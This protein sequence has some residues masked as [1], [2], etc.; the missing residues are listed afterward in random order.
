MKKRVLVLSVMVIALLTA[1]HPAPVG[2]Q[3][4]NTYTSIIVTDVVSGAPVVGSTFVTDVK[5]SITNNAAPTLGV[6]GVELWLPFDPAVVS[7]VDHDGNPGNGTQVQ[8]TNGFFDGNL[9]VGANEVI[10]GAMPA[11]APADCGV[12]GACVHIAV[13]HTG[14]SGAITD[15]TG[16]VAS[17]TWAALAVGSPAISIAVVPP[18][19]LPGSVLS[20]A[21]GGT[22]DINST[23]VP[24]ITIIDAGQINGRVTR[25]GAQA[26]HANTNV[27]ALAIGNGVAATNVTNANGNFS[28][29]V[30]VGATYTINASY[31]GYLQAQK[32]SVYVVGATV[33]IG[34]TTLRGGDVNA[35]NCINI[36]DIVSIISKFG[37]TGLP[38]TDPEDIND[39]GT[40]NILDLT[41]AAG[42]FTKC[43]PT[44]W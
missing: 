3:G 6:M 11:T 44:A 17:I 27:I 23:S 8:L 18:G 36:L 15:K 40:I 22:I 14:G 42:N 28:L 34:T 32:N 30:P 13:T 1:L 33:G 41:I 26:G 2:A 35:D 20:T 12:T 7:V 37:T 24:T 31:P 39:D 38:A 16:T 5:V 19:V 4:P 10:V 9:A 21:G 43:G 25:Q 29:V